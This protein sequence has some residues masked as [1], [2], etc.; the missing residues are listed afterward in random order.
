VT[1][2]TFPGWGDFV[3]AE[4]ARLTGFGASTSSGEPEPGT[5]IKLN[6]NENPYGCS[7]RV[8]QALATFTPLNIYPDPGQVEIRRLLAEYIQV[9]PEYVFVT[10][11]GEQLIELIMLMLIDSGDKIINCVPTFD[12]FRLKAQMHGG[13]MVNIP[14]DENFAVDVAAVK[15]A[16]DDRTKL[17][18]LAT[19]NNPTGTLIPQ[20]DILEIVASS[21]VPVL[22]DE[23]YGEF[24]EQ[25]V[26]PLISQY[27]NMLILRTLSK[28]A[29]LA[30][31]RIGYGIFAPE[32]VRHMLTIKPIYGVNSISTV[33]VRESIADRDYL[34]GN[35]RAIIAERERL[36]HEISQFNFLKPFPSQANFI[37]CHVRQMS[38]SQLAQAL[39]ARGILI[40][41]FSVAGL[42]N[43]VRI[44]VGKPE[45]TDA[46]L[47]ALRAIGDSLQ[48]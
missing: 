24:S 34:M 8:Q 20:E 31:L 13:V 6:C 21:G 45:H 23:A 25:T 46:L 29:G 19:P 12:V 10:A 16:I 48:G 2:D 7:P 1:D 39:R 11:G 26:V 47:E 36:F 18:C 28:W 9:S 38:G 30:G 40:G 35:V 5:V 42:E 15:A 3:R 4:V 37:F 22:V 33:A 32:I 27:K 41:S 43:S 17:I 14:R 44:T